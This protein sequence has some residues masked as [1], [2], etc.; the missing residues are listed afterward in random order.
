MVF[1]Y[2]LA[3][4]SHVKLMISKAGRFIGTFSRLRPNLTT[5]SANVVYISLIRP[6]LLIT[7]CSMGLLNTFQFVKECVLGRCPQYV[8]DYFTCN[9]KI[10]RRVARQSI[11]LHL[12]AVRREITKKIFFTIDVLFLIIFLDERILFEH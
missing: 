4:N 3:W 12:S 10:H 11:L 6:I 5:P 7:A 9:N 8:K 1:N 2:R